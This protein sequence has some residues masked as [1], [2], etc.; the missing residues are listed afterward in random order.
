MNINYDVITFFQ[1]VF[2]L[3]RPG[4][5]IFADITKTATFSIKTIFIDSRKVERTRYFE[6]KYNLYMHFLI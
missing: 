1:N 5:A 6:S 3:R 2:N 4:G